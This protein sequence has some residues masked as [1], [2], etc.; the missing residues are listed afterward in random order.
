MKTIHFKNRKEFRAWLE[1][2]YK[3]R[4]L[5]ML[6]YKKHTGM[7][8]IPYGDSVEE[9]IC[10]GWIDGKIRSI[11]EKRYVRRFTPRREKSMWS[12]INK[13]R[14]LVMLKRGRVKKIGREKIPKSVLRKQKK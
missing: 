11:D 10:F 3:E 5:W 12:E 8:T 9:A 7:K 13:G 1:K 2:N 14:A 4:E 6:I